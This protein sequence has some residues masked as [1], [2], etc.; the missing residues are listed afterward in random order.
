MGVF[1]APIVLDRAPHSDFYIFVADQ[2]L[3]HGNKS[4]TPASTFLRPHNLYFNT[5]APQQ[6]CPA[7]I[8]LLRTRGR[9]KAKRPVKAGKRW[10][11]G[12][13]LTRSPNALTP[14]SGKGNTAS[15]FRPIDSFFFS[16][17]GFCLWICLASVED[18]PSPPWR[19]AETPF[20]F[21]CRP[22]FF[23]LLVSLRS[24]FDLFPLAWLLKA[25]FSRPY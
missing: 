7:V 8:V 21:F 12:T 4:I 22:L 20:F 5:T 3:H 15:I 19:K 10:I 17:G 6:G 9:E 18:I 11:D 1:A 16:K 24:P 23:V 25:S 2:S 13:Q 14:S